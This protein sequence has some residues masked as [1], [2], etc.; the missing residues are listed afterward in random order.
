ML[1]YFVHICSVKEFFRAYTG[2]IREIPFYLFQQ[3]NY[4]FAINYLHS[5]SL[6]AEL[7]VMISL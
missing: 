3:R 1:D 7:Q 5:V 4:F 6:F 2:S